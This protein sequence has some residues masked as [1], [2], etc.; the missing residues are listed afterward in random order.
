MGVICLFKKVIEGGKYTLFWVE[1]NVW[2]NDLLEFNFPKV[3]RN[4][5]EV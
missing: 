2:R 4:F 3:R 1:S 5:R